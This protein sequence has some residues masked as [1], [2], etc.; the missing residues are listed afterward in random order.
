MVGLDIDEAKK[1]IEEEYIPR[2]R[3]EELVGKPDRDVLMTTYF[4]DNVVE[5]ARSELIA[6]ESNNASSDEIYKK[7]DFYRDL[8]YIIKDQMCNYKYPEDRQNDIS[9]GVNKIDKLIC[10]YLKKKEA[11]TK[12][13][14]KTTN[15]SRALNASYTQ[16]ITQPSKASTAKAQGLPGTPASTASTNKQPASTKL[17]STKDKNNLDR[18]MNNFNKRH[19]KQ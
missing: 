9:R 2:K 3:L 12:P 15:S 6:L 1:F 8:L 13:A 14:E 19:N 4:V 5:K 7:L 16:Q 10:K 17:W 18:L 11:Q